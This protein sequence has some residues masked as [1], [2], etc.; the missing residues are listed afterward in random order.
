MKTYILNNDGLFAQL[1]IDGVST[2]VWHNV[3]NNQEYLQWLS[4]G[5][6]PLPAD[7]TAL[8]PASEQ[9]TANP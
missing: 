8:K 3:E 6:Q 9:G 2:Q 7:G 5:N 1:V 4:E